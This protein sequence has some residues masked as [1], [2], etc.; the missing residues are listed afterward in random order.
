MLEARPGVERRQ[1]LAG[2]VL[3]VRHEAA[4]HGF[5]LSARAG[6]DPIGQVGREHAAVG[7]GA[8][9]VRR[10]G[11]HPRR[12]EV[13]AGERAVAH[14]AVHARH[15]RDR[16]TLLGQALDLRP[17]HGAVVQVILL[18][19]QGLDLQV[20]GIDVTPGGQHQGA[21]PLYRNAARILGHVQRCSTHVRHGQEIVAGLQ[22]G[23]VAGTHISRI[24][25]HAAD[26]G[27]G[28]HPGLLIGRQ[29][30]PQDGTLSGINAARFKVACQ[31]QHIRVVD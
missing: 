10:H 9:K 20:V 6:L 30:K 15:H 8:L 12:V 26:I 29:V 2:H 13:G 21:G 23:H 24:D 18:V 11:C 27:P 3:H 4:A 5:F 22:Q 7:A 25:A 19:A 14:R 17:G 1:R 16:G 28:P 31:G